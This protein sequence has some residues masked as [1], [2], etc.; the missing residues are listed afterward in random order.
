MSFEHEQQQAMRLLQ[1]LEDGALPT[2][3]A[4][5]LFE[6]ADPALVYFI[7]AWL[8]AWYPPSHSAAQGVLGRIVALCTASPQVAR[9]AK[10]G[11]KDALVAWFEEAYDY[12]DLQRDAFIELIVEKLEG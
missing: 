6:S 3:R 10:K 4:R 11:E 9:M 2:D 7:F 5:G 12:R 8:R 1:A